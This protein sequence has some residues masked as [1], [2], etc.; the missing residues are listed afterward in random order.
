MSDTHRY[1]LRDLGYL[2]KERAL[3][4]R[5]KAK[6][7]ASFGNAAFEEGRAI[8]YW[9]VVSTMQNQAVAFQLPLEDLAL[10]GFNPDRDLY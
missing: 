7:A 3:E 10:D 9:E 8:A 5:A 6:A 1:Y 2:L 4:A